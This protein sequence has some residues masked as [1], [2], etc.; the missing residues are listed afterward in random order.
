MVPIWRLPPSILRKNKKKKHIVTIEWQMIHM[1]LLLQLNVTI[2]RKT[3][4]NMEQ[5]EQ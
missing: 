2:S 1:T 3:W 5:I 4:Q